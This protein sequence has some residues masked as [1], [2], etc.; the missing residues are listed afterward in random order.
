MGGCG[1]LVHSGQARLDP[2]GLGVTVTPD[3]CTPF[4]FVQHIRLSLTHAPSEIHVAEF[5]V[6]VDHI[7]QRAPL[8][9]SFGVSIT[10]STHLSP[11]FTPPGSQ[12]YPSINCQGVGPASIS[13]SDLSTLP[14]CQAFIAHQ[15]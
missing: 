1:Y 6:P 4:S 15:V 2:P 12:N 14:V 11:M 5:F 13:I 3:A 10:S 7:T 9:S 8:S